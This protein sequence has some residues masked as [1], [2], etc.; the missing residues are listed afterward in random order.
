MANQ[1]HALLFQDSSK[2][3]DR[4]YI[5]PQ[6]ANAIWVSDKYYSLD[7]LISTAERLNKDGDGSIVY[8]V[9]SLTE[10]NSST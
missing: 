7:D 2:G 10:L 9:F 6:M 5:A 4:W 8:K 3:D 1:L